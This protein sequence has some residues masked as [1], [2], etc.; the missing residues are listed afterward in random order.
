MDDERAA[1]APGE[2]AVDHPPPDLPP[3]LLTDPPGDVIVD[4]GALADFARDLAAGSGPVAIDAERASGY[5]Y[6]QRAYLIQI[7]R[8]G[9]GTA[10]I[11]PHAVMRAQ[12]RSDAADLGQIDRAIGPAEWILHAATQDLPCLA[13]V[14]MRPRRLFDTEL[15]GRLLGRDRVSLA[16]LVASELGLHLAKGHGSADW[17]L[18]PM[19]PAQLHYA[20]LDVEALADLRAILEAEL[21]ARDRWAWAEQEF[22]A[23]LDFQPKARAQDAWRRTSGIHRLRKPRQM[24]IVRALWGARDAMAAAADI[25]PGRV[26]PDAA[27]IA[28]AQGMPTSPEALIA[29]EG[30]TGRGQRRRAQQWMA[31]ILDAL[32]LT[33]AECPPVHAPQDGPPQ[34]RLWAERNPSA[35]RRLAA[36]RPA[37]E[38]LSGELGIAAEVLIS[39]STV[40]DLCWQPPTDSSLADALAQRNARPWQITLVEPVIAPAF[41][42]FSPPSDSHG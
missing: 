5:R 18:R 1:R 34:P 28:A 14:G 33:D 36:V 17:S 31:A 8:A 27:I 16:A 19:T 24:A 11:D 9:A 10:L 25:A 4:L 32:D 23:L 15:A 37:I 40:R 3:L 29:T 41:D 35:A 12:R 13:E 20:A 22:H 39:P 42:Q 6:S 2:P 7:R 38:R 26:L 30:F 21:H